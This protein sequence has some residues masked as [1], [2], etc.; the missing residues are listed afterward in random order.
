[1]SRDFHNAAIPEPVILL[2]QRLHPY[3]LGHH[4]L[5]ERWESP[6][7]SGGKADVVDLYSAI[8]ICCNEY[9]EFL[10]LV[11]ED[12]IITLVKK[13]SKRIGD[14]DF[15]EIAQAFQDYID[16]SF[17]NFPKFW[18]EDNGNDGKVGTPFTQSIKVRLLRNTNLTEQEILNRP[19]ALCMWDVITL[20]EQ[21]GVL[22]INTKEDDELIKQK[23]A[24]E[25][26]VGN[27]SEKDISRYN[28]N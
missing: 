26:W 1:M 17:S 4:I 8:L 24:F 16:D 7:V 5:L 10:K 6:F 28:M 11:R 14:F 22:T 15:K 9:D 3:S 23:D 2:G 27:M 12:D 13:W 20:L 21:D 25:E 18:K 19:L